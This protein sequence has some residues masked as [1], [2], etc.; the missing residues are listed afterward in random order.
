MANSFLSLLAFIPILLLFVLMVWARF[1]AIKAMPVTWIV[2]L[3]LAYYVWGVP[4][5]T[6]LAS[7]ISGLV[8]A[9]QIM[10]IVFGALSLLFMLQE[11]GAIASIN[12]GFTKISS[13]RRVQA[14]IIAWFF[15]GFIEG[16]AGFGTPAALVAP[17]LMSLGFPALAAAII[18]LAFNSTPVSFGAVGTP[19]LLG[20]GSSLESPSVIQSVTDSGGTFNSFIHD[21]GAWSAAM[22]I[23][24][25]TLL[26]VLVS[27]LLT[28]FFGEKKSF[29]E[30]LEIWPFALFSSL[31]FLVP[32]FL[33]A[34][35]LGPE[36]PSIIGP[37]VGLAIIVPTAKAGFL[38]PKKV[39]DFPERGKWPLSWLGSIQAENTG[40]NK[41]VP[42]FRAWIPYIL[43][44]L[45]LVVSRVPSLGIGSWL[46]GISLKITNIFGTG[47][48]SSFEPLK[49]PGLFPFILITLF[50]F[51]FFRMSRE[52]SVFV[53]KETFSK[54]KM[55][56]VALVFAVPM[57]RLMMD[58][59][60]NGSGFPGM[61]IVLANYLAGLSHG[62]WPLFA[63]F[64]GALGTFIA[65][66]NTV[67]NMLFSIFQYSIAEN[68]GISKTI[69]LSLQNVGGAIGNMIC[70]HN[71]IAV[72]ATVGLTGVEGL[73]IKRNIVPVVIYGLIAGAVGL[74]IVYCI[75]PNLF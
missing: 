38:I 13:D 29:R 61:P 74:V 68:L 18:A 9:F 17:L 69:I 28:R 39:W 15:G 46:S 31:C 14:I 73:I 47:L 63:P 59:G 52:Q 72:C 54:I 3:G 36:F 7:N 60:N 2:T 40:Q 37:L 57:V 19:T 20:I 35:L 66:S 62:I 53:W 44:G 55:P 8:V 45:L 21:V 6:L 32:Y 10:L 34:W 1:P 51:L 50:G 22:H 33:S 48:S 16:A 25:S 75:A 65:G 11:S 23:I 5:N 64:V 56:A 27:G 58:S 49:N 26:L 30:G 67:S 24:P 43:I 12:R 42:L 4:V 41:P 70:V 71:I